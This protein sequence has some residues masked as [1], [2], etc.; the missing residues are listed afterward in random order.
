MNSKVHTAG[1]QGNHEA[2]F[3]TVDVAPTG[4]T[5]G[6]ALLSVAD[7]RAF[8]KRVDWPTYPDSPRGH[9]LRG[10]R[11]AEGLS[12]RSGGAALGL[13]M[14]ELSALEVGAKVFAAEE[15]W[16]RAATVLGRA[17]AAARKGSR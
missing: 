16:M 4:T 12:L 5:P 6:T 1:E 11:H 3:Q 7:G 17:G 9:A 14:A 8:T 13:S 10:V 15:D 2:P